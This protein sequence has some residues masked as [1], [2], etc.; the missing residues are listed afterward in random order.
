M[1][2]VLILLLALAPVLTIGAVLIN[3]LLENAPRRGKWPFPPPK[4]RATSPRR[5][6]K[7]PVEARIKI[8]TEGG[9]LLEGT[10]EYLA[11]R[12]RRMEG[13]PAARP[14]ESAEDARRFLRE[15]EAAG[16]IL[17]RPE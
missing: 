17:I 16:R 14:R 6:N 12:L 11:A 1:S 4:R 2:T 5:G 13:A 10:P 7:P 3:L 15:W 8:L 9:L